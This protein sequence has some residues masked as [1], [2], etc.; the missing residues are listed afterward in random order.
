MNDKESNYLN[1]VE[2]SNNLDNNSSN[3]ENSTY[4]V[5]EACNELD[6]EAGNDLGKERGEHQQ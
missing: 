5:V 4:R 3:D 6:I 1:S 2:A